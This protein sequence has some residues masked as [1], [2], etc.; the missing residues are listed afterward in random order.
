MPGESQELKDAFVRIRQGKGTAHD[1]DLLY[2]F[3]CVELMDV[4]PRHADDGALQEH[5]GRRNFCRELLNLLQGD[6][7]GSRAATVGRDVEGAGLSG[8]NVREARRSGQ[9]GRRRGLS[10]RVVDT[11]GADQA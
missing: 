4:L 10:R 1:G 8:A 7:H 6:M 11:G 9:T 5:N 2:T 3:V